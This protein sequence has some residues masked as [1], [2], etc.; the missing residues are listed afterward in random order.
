MLIYAVLYIR[1]PAAITPALTY[2]VQL[3]L[4][5]RAMILPEM[6]YEWLFLTKTLCDPEVFWVMVTAIATV[7]LVV[8]TAGLIYVGWIQLQELVKTSKA[9]FL[10]R[11][12]REFFAIESRRFIFLIEHGLLIFNVSKD[13][14]GFFSVKPTGSSVLR[15]AMRELLVDREIYTTFE[16]DDVLLGPL[17]DV[18]SF[19]KMGNVDLKAVYLVFG[20]YVNDVMEND[21][22]REY[23][24]WARVDDRAP[25]IYDGLEELYRKLKKFDARPLA[26]DF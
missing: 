24:E 6:H 10:E 18:A 8:A 4:Q 19:E 3:H 17:E 16:M 14:I 9:D 2:V 5:L 7:L 26:P 13:N 25:D 15:D 23:I 1:P 21:A 20:Q 11:M 12:K 22:I